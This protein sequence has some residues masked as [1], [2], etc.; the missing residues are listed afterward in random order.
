M[1]LFKNKH[2]KTKFNNESISNADKL[3]AILSK[4]NILA[5]SNNCDDW[6]VIF[7]II[8]IMTDKINSEKSIEILGGE[9]RRFC[10]YPTNQDSYITS[11]KDKVIYTDKF[12]I[13]LGKDPVISSHWNS[14]R[15]IDCLKTIGGKEKSWKYQADNHRYTLY[16]PMGITVT[17][18]GNHS[19]YSGVVKGVG[20]L[21]F[22]PARDRVFDVSHYYQKVYFD[23]EYYRN[24]INN[25][26]IEKA[27]FECGCIFEI[28]RI[29]HSKNISFLELKKSGLF[30]F[31]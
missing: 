9:L 17:N 15:L 11:K 31:F 13:N 22:I 1:K 28:G 8:K 29:L 3:N 21:D 12:S 30:E 6:K 10:F 5:D 4:V 20:K 18:G 16:L 14:E 23:G 19:I 7:L 26:I 2:R 25:S 27:N 24:K